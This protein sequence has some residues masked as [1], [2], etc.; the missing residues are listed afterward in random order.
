MTPRILHDIQGPSHQPGCVPTEQDLP[1]PVR[2][3]RA[4]KGR[5]VPSRPVPHLPWDPDS[6]IQV[7]PR[8]R[9][10]LS[11]DNPLEGGTHTSRDF[12]LPAPSPRSCRGGRGHGG[13]VQPQQRAPGPAAPLSPLPT[14]PPPLPQG[15][16]HYPRDTPSPEKPDPSPLRFCAT[17]S[18]SPGFP[19][20]PSFWL[21][22]GMHFFFLEK[23]L[24]I[25]ILL[26]TAQLE[27][28]DSGGDPEAEPPAMF[29]TPKEEGCSE[30]PIKQ[31]T[32]R[33]LC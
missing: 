7:P 30:I 24:L 22:I 13:A 12:G 20:R 8:V 10:H 29:H 11:G 9:G 19:P 2:P 15:A 33:M 1:L 21:R 3:Q 18:F 4:P 26:I 31:G 23:L 25:W 32:G 6:R 16:P 5:P 27:R 28:S 17:Q 14:P